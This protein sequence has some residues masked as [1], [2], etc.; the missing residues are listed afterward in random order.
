MGLT[1]I[2]QC[3]Q[4]QLAR[5]MIQVAL[6]EALAFPREP[7]AAEPQ[8]SCT[9]HGWSVMGRGSEIRGEPGHEGRPCSSDVGLR[10]EHAASQRFSV[11]Y[12]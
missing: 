6:D 1:T 12:L 11:V 8:E 10:A 7:S 2:M 5:I 4:R 9:D 3:P